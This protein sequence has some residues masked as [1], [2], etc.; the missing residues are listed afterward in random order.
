MKKIFLPVPVIIFSWVMVFSSCK[1][2]DTSYLIYST[3][4]DSSKTRY[5]EMQKSITQYAK[6]TSDTR[7][8]L[9]SARLDVQLKIE[10][11]LIKFRQADHAKDLL[12]TPIYI[13]IA[14]LLLSILSFFYSNRIMQKGKEAKQTHNE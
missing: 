4:E 14:S 11:Y 13:S 1:S 5:E 6:D 2:H 9:L 12:W 3:H 7:L 8:K 10:D